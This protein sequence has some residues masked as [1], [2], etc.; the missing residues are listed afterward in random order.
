MVPLKV[1]RISV[2]SPYVDR[3]RTPVFASLTV[4]SD[5]EPEISIDI[6]MIFAYPLRHLEW[7]CIIH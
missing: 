3:E 2:Q 7:L 1:D 5:V 6:L 4:N